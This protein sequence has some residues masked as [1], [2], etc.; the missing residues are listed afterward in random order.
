MQMKVDLP[1]KNIKWSRVDGAAAASPLSL[2][3]EVVPAWPWDL[4]KKT[5]GRKV[6]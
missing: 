5:S 6:S 4:M 1:K 2:R 3:P